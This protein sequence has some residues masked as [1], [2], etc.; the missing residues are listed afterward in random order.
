SR[1]IDH[2]LP[3]WAYYDQDYV[4]VPPLAFMLHYAA[5]RVAPGVDAVIL[6]KVVAQIEIAAAF[7][8]AAAL[9]LPVFRL[10][11]TLLAMSFLIWP[12]PF[13][14][15]FID[16]YFPTTT[17]LLVQ[18]VFVAWVLGRVRDWADGNAIVT[19]RA[20]AVAAAL[21]A[22]GAFADAIGLAVDTF[23]GLLF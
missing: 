17:A 4:T 23:V 15:W 18:L 16:G 14:V 5:T 10:C 2:G 22:L 21:A 12:P 7:L 19:G 1:S 20:L 3:E 13:L 8:A 9:L 11:P 6:A